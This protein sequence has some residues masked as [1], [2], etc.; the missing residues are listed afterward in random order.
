MTNYIARSNN[1][2][3]HRASHDRAHCNQRMYISGKVSDKTVEAAAPNMFC[4]K[5]FPNGKPN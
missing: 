4:E 1:G 2:T 3:Y 5:C